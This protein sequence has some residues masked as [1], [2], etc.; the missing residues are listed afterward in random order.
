[1]QE[2]PNEIPKLC[3]KCGGCELGHPVSVWDKMPSGCGFSGWIFQEREKIKQKIRKK[4]EK[5]IEL[6][7]ITYF[8]TPKDI[9]LNEEEIE[10]L[11][12][13]IKLYSK[14]GSQDW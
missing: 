7:S 10:R 12:S 14:Y 4:K 13:E 9:Q 3:T 6:K 2:F 11:E 5:I 1:M 8:S